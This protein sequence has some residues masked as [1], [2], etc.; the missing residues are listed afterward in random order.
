MTMPD[1]RL[2]RPLL[3]IGGLLPALAG[4]ACLSPS[5]PDAPEARHD[6]AARQLTDVDAVRDG[7]AVTLTWTADGPVDVLLS[8]DPW[9]DPEQMTV[10]SEQDPDGRHVVRDLQG[11]TRPYFYMRTADGGGQRVAV[12]LLPLEGGRNFRDLGGYPTLDGRRVRWGRVF[13]SGMMANLTDA[14][15]DYLSALGIRVVCDFRSNE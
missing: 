10:I 12:R 6:A 1:V 4:A 13:R 11:V 7:A 5:S 3:V 9:A 8:D 14:D 2:V 15:Y